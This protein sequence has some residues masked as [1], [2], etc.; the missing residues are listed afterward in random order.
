MPA[1]K[2]PPL[3][4]TARFRTLEPRGVP[5]GFLMRGRAASPSLLGGYALLVLILAAGAYGGDEAD[6]ETR[7]RQA[8]E[9]LLPHF[10]DDPKAFRDRFAPIFFREVKD[11]DLEKALKD[12]FKNHGAG[13]QVRVVRLAAAYEGDVEFVF[14][15]NARIP[16]TLRLE[17]KPPYRI[18][19]LQFHGAYKEN[20]TLGELTAEIRALPGKAAFSFAKLGPPITTFWEHN[21]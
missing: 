13:K 19:G 6:G 15:K 3:V 12:I 4:S 14:E 1:A 18:S 10:A 7:L 20:E 21:S 11:T 5:G 9:R 2:V 17:S 8:G 16:T